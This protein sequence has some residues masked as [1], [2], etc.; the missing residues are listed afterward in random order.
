MSGAESTSSMLH[1]L[2]ANEEF[3]EHTHTSSCTHNTSQESSLF[4]KKPSTNAQSISPFAMRSSSS[5]V[6]RETIEAFISGCAAI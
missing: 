2:D 6:L 5:A 3:G 4:S 1:V